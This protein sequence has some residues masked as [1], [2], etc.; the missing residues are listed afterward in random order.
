MFSG[1]QIDEALA[2]GLERD[3][4]RKEVDDEKLGLFFVNGFDEKNI[5]PNIHYMSAL[6]SASNVH[7]LA[8]S[9]DVCLEGTTNAVSRIKIK[10]AFTCSL[11]PQFLDV[12]LHPKEKDCLSFHCPLTWAGNL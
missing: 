8:W 7:S 3:I 11:I 12:V 1:G 9:G 4:Q 5:F 2:Y 6:R 10:S